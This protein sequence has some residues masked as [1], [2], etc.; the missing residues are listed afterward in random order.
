MDIMTF[1]GLIQRLRAMRKMPGRRGRAVR[2]YL[3]LAL[4]RS[5]SG[6]SFEETAR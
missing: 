4:R 3:D 1:G 2:A 6:L 5:G